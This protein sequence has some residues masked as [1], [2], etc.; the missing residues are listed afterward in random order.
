MTAPWNPGRTAGAAIDVLRSLSADLTTAVEII[1]ANDDTRLDP[2]AHHVADAL[3]FI[4][5]MEDEVGA[6]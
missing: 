2:V 5:E 6:P 1:R 3:A 4:D